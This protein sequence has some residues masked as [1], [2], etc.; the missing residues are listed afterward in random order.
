MALADI[1]TKIDADAA[2]AAAAILAAAE[3]DA[4]ATTAA[5]EAEATAITETSLSDAERTESK[6]K[7]RAIAAAHHEAKFALQALKVSTIDSVFT[8]VEQKLGDM[9]DTEYETFVSARAA[10]LKGQ[11]GNII[12]DSAKEASTLALLKK[13]GIDAASVTAAPIGGGFILETAEAR[14]DHSFTT[15][16]AR[17][18]ELLASEVAATLFVTK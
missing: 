1:I 13:A 9:T 17:A 12:V 11:S 4:T 18:R 3:A 6:V 8:A 7:E 15:V 2:A 14:F 16:L 10:S 5:A